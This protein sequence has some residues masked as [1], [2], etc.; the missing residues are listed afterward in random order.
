MLTRDF[1]ETVQARA[2]C[3]RAFCQVLL[4][5]VVAALLQGDLATGKAILSDYINATIGFEALGM[6]PARDAA[7]GVS[8]R[9]CQG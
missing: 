4:E 9:A 1:K 5:E 8:L 2:R 6:P 7:G 3:D